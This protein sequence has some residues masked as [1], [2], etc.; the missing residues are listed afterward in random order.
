MSIFFRPNNLYFSGLKN[1]LTHDFHGQKFFFSPYFL[2]SYY[3]LPQFFLCPNLFLDQLTDFFPTQYFW[4]QK[5]P[6]SILLKTN[7]FNQHFFFNPR[8][9]L[10]RITF[11]ST[12]KG[13][14]RFCHSKE[15]TKSLNS[16]LWLKEGIWRRLKILMCSLVVE[17]PLWFFSLCEMPF[18]NIDRILRISSFLQ[19]DKI[20]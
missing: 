11:C 13:P 7:I 4:R 18:F 3:C 14:I 10:D 12:L 17:E 15:K 16:D 20:W 9:F 5:N 1:F 2:D 6:F 8:Y 19:S